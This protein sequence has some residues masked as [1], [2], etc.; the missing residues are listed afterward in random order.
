MM[1]IA[2][3]LGMED[4]E[5]HQYRTGHVL[6]DERGGDSL[7]VLRHVER[8]ARPEGDPGHELG[9]P[10]LHHAAAVGPPL[11]DLVPQEVRDNVLQVVIGRQHA[12]DIVHRRENVDG[13]ENSPRVARRVLHARHR[14]TREE[15]YLVLAQQHRHVRRP[16]PTIVL[17]APL[18]LPF[19]AGPPLANDVALSPPQPGA[20]A[21]VFV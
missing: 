15:T 19:F 6:T 8:A 11:H 2:V 9:G 3:G 5:T 17:T 4:R 18:F 16:P 10:D 21:G 7:G 1:K 14:V 12:P 20:E 13:R